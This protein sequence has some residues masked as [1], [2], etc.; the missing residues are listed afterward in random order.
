MPLQSIRYHYLQEEEYLHFLETHH[1]NVLNS[2]KEGKLTDETVK[3]L[4]K[5]A[6]DISH[7]YEKK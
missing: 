1:K 5:T 4:E 2:L 7:K 6:E 3:I